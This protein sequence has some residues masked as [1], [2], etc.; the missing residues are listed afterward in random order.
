MFRVT[1][2]M[3]SMYT[4]TQIIKQ[5]LKIIWKNPILWFFGF[6]AALLGGIADLELFLG[7][8]NFG[9]KGILFS[10]CQGLAEGG[11]FTMAGL[12]G[13]SVHP[14]YF[15]IL[16]L[17]FLIALAISALVIWLGIVSQS[18]LIKKTISFSKNESPDWP[19]AFKLGI[20][21]FW[22]VLGLNALSRVIIWFFLS[23]IG[24]LTLLKF[25]GL[26]VIFVFGFSIFIALSLIVSFIAKYAICG[27]VLKNWHFSETI[28]SAWKILS[29]NWLIT[30]EIAVMVFIINLVVNSVLV[31]FSSQTLIYALTVH[32]SS[33]FSLI[34]IVLAIAIVFVFIQALLVVFHWT[35]WTIVFKLLTDKKQALTSALERGFGK[36]FG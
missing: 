16:A 25:S 9:G 5:A 1:C 7:G 23:I 29:Q 3:K 2:Y 31:F 6:W 4:Y 18:V 30:L 27:A 13:L 11:L 32:S 8:W 34:M 20:A 10:F 33:L 24:I 26:T 21:K 14:F 12:Q 36:L 17:I 22:P 35:I 19:G 15:F 28:K